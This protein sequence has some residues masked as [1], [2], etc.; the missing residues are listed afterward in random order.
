MTQEQLHRWRAL[1]RSAPWLLC[2]CRFQEPFQPLMR[3]RPRMR[4]AASKGLRKN[5]AGLLPKRKKVL[6]CTKRL[7]RRGLLSCCSFSSCQHFTPNRLASSTMTVGGPLK[8]SFG[9]SGAFCNCLHPI[10]GVGEAVQ[11]AMQRVTTAAR[12]YSFQ[13]SRNFFFATQLLCCPS[14]IRPFHALR[15]RPRATVEL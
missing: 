14:L 4:T 10:S 3:H 12:P 8:P 11:A 1:P 6:R 15:H 9:L 5:P 7:H 13:V 2:G